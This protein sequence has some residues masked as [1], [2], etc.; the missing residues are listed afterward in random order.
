MK[1]RQEGRKVMKNRGLYNRISIALSL[2]LLFISGCT[3]IKPIVT[4]D[5][6]AVETLFSHEQYRTVLQSHVNELGRVDYVGLKNQPEQLEL[7]Y[8]AITRYSP[9]SHPQLFPGR[10]YELAYWINA[11]NAGVLKTV[12][13]YYPIDSVLDV[14]NPALFF[15][16]TDK[17]GFFFFQRLTFGG[18]TT[19]LYSLESKVIRDRYKDPRIHFALNCASI[20][21]PKLPRIPFT[22]DRLDNQ[23]DYETRKFLAEPRNFSINHNEKTIYLSSIFNWYEEDFTSWH[24][25]QYPGE[26]SSLLGY[27]RLYLNLEKQILLDSV[28]RNYVIRFIEYDWGL[29]MQ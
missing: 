26:E 20:G 29:N 3:G 14:K 16:L 8:G 11:Y 22:G 2:L 23:L 17:A 28:A 27:I 21:C 6:L 1:N 5:H 9:D 25:E 12:I 18:A 19:S 15:F 4:D 10:A 24:Q 7:Y 13:T